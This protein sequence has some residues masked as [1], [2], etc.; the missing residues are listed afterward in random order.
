MSIPDPTSITLAHLSDVH[1]PP[2]GQASWRAFCNK[3]ALSVISWKRHRQHHHLRAVSNAILQDIARQHPDVIANTGDLTNFG[4]PPEF[5]ESAKWLEALPAPVCI[6]PGNHDT[7]THQRW[8]DG[9]RYWSPWMT[10]APEHFPYCRQFGNLALI[11]VN[12]GIPSPP[13]M[14]YGRVGRAQR[15]RLRAILHQTRQ[16]CRVVMIHHPPR[17]GLVPWRKSLLD[18]RNVAA[19]LKEGGAAIVL[20]GHSHDSTVTTVPGTDIP[21]I[22]IASAS[23]RSRRPW[24]DAAWNRIRVGIQGAAW[25]IKLTQRRIT[26]EQTFE[27]VLHREWIRAR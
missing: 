16:L 19:V 21:L 4:L 17:A 7:M 23:L 6:V 14:A 15:Q 18:H 25:H 13:F 26:E 20:H 24:R 10:D 27:D 11:G 5:V 1:L 22:G 12:S 3:R 9:L 2:P 8:D